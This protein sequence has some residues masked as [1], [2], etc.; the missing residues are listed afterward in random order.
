MFPD[1][2]GLA[3]WV[4]VAS[5]SND[6]AL[7][8]VEGGREG[9]SKEG[10]V[11]RH[12]I[13]RKAVN[14]ELEVGGGK[15]KSLP[16]VVGDGEGLIEAGGKSFKKRSVGRG[17]DVAINNGESNSA[18]AIDKGLERNR[19]LGVGLFEDGGWDVREA[20]AD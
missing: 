3:I 8:V 1:R 11:I 6:E 14:G 19:E 4:E 17:G 18:F 13:E 15:A 20:D 16:R 12:G 10:V 9:G 5:S 7:G 2:T